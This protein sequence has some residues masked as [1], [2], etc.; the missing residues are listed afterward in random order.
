MFQDAYAPA[1]SPSPARPA[2]LTGFSKLTSLSSIISGIRLNAGGRRLSMRIGIENRGY[3]MVAVFGRRM[4]AYA[5]VIALSNWAALSCVAQDAKLVAQ[6]ANP[7]PDTTPA[8]PPASESKRAFS[9]SCDLHVTDAVKVDGVKATLKGSKDPLEIRFTPF[10]PKDQTLSAIF[11]LQVLE[12]A[13]RATA[14]QMIDAV[15]KIAEARDGKRRFAAYSVANYLTP[16][17]NFSASKAD[18]DKAVRGLKQEVV[19]TQLYQ[20]TLEAIEKLSKEPGDRKAIILVGDGNS[21]DTGYTHEQVVAAAKAA[22]ITVHALGFIEQATELPRFQVL[23]RLAEDTGGLRRE[24]RLGRETKFNVTPKFASEVLENGG[25]ARIVIKDPPGPVTVSLSA[26]LAGG[27]SELL[28]VAVATPAPVAKVTPQPVKPTPPPPPQSMEDR[29]AAWVKENR[30]I[31]LAIG[32]GFALAAL[33]F[34]LFAFGRKPTALPATTESKILTDKQGRPIIYGWLEGLDGDSSKYPLQTTNI[35]IGRH[36]DND[37]CLQNDSISR[38]HALVHFN[39]DTRKFLITDLGGNNGV[40]V[41]KVRQK[42]HELN[43]GD[44]IE[45]GEVR[46]RFRANSEFA[47]ESR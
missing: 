9:V 40:V 25:S 14:L 33:G 28:D 43:D 46:L 7:I 42:T 45:L 17:A 47:G 41:N 3:W 8:E 13:R 20:A 26:D 18:F 6:C 30:F 4:V 23:R 21:D 31:S 34:L 1:K 10:D 19:P 16:L 2:E 38:R 37:V 35:R 44:L 27:R 5:I 24:V 29:I 39:A 36:R 15:V 11:L 12:P 32:V 22:N